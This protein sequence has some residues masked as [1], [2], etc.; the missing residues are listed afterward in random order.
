[1]I[2]LRDRVGTNLPWPHFFVAV[3]VNQSSGEVGD[4]MCFPLAA[5]VEYFVTVQT[6]LVNCTVFFRALLLSGDTSI[7]LKKLLW[8]SIE[9][10]RLL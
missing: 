4:S 3:S 7:S 6:Q 10:D 8:F 1:M 9:L 5:D 2:A